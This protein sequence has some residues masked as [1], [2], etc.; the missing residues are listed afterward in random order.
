M[1]MQLAEG[2]YG[3]PGLYRK[4]IDSVPKNN[5]RPKSVELVSMLQTGNMDYAWEY[6]SVAI[7]HGLKYVSLPPEINLGD[8]RSEALYR[9]AVVHTAGDKPGST[10]EMKGG[11]ITYGV[12]LINSAP[13]RD[14]AVLF[15]KYMLSPDGGLKILRE[16]GQPPLVPV[17]VSDAAML[18]VLPEALR[19]LAAALK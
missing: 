1:A 15:L 13:N 14:D 17:R 5:I 3:K 4:L 10:M 9:K 18:G 12:A 2:H 7:Q 11:S 19:P 6:L 16:M 8:F